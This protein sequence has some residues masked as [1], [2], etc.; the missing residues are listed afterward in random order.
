M[1]GQKLVAALARAGALGERAISH[2]VLVDVVEPTVPTAAFTVEARRGDLAEPGVTSSLV[3]CRPDVVFHLA[4]V[5][6]GEAEADV[7]KGYRANLDGTRLL[8]D[9]L[10]AESNREYLP[11]VVVASSIAVFGAP[12]PDVI[13]DNEQLTP[14]TS[15]GTQ[16]AIVELLLADYSRREFVDGIALRLPTI[17]VRPGAPNRAASGFFS[18]IIREPLNGREAVLPVSDDVRGGRIINNG[19]ISANVPRPNSAPYTAA[20]HAITGLTKSTSLDARPHD[21]ACGQI[22]IGNA[23]TEM[24]APMQTTGMPQADGRI[25]LE[26]TFDVADVARAV[27]FMATLPL[28]A[29]VQFM[30]VMATKMPYIGRG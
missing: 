26:P 23:A 14:L 9:A 24:T 11:R 15:Y 17:C 16:K 12:F 28:D 6:S 4:A 5:V 10:R 1:L 13:G 25:A 2:L 20:K 18:S 3:A 8:L 30:T 7:D 19:S 27:V 29:N 22:D 21:I